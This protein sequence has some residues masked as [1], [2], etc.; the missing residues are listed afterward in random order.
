MD[1]SVAGKQGATIDMWMMHAGGYNK[2]Y[3][4]SSEYAFM[5]NETNY[6]ANE[7]GWEPQQVQAAV[8]VA[9][10]ARMENPEVKRRTEEISAKRGWI[11]YEQNAKGKTV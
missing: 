7:L 10:K 2:D 8:W 9:I 3:S 5:E 4:N 6:L 1:L 11:H